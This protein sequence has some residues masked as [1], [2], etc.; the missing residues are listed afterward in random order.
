MRN[1][2]QCGAVTVAVRCPFC[3]ADLSFIP[4]FDAPGAPAAPDATR[5]MPAAPAPSFAPPPS[6]GRYQPAMADQPPPPMPGAGRGTKRWPLVVGVLVL[7]LVVA[8]AI[9][10][11]ARSGPDRGGAVPSPT[12]SA[13]TASAPSPTVSEPPAP[14]A[15]PVPAPAPEISAAPVAPPAV[16][17]PAV[18]VAPAPSRPVHADVIADATAKECRR[19]PNGPWAAV[20]VWGT[21][22]CPFAIN[23]HDAYLESGLGGRPGTVEAYS[24]TT[25]QWY[26]MTCSASNPVVTCQGGVRARILLYDGRLVPKK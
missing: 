21:T 2:P 16:T 17:P 19:L 6:A 5:V 1:C 13:P 18:T 3:G 26:E 7:V 4:P 20:G 12:T 23:V 25:E 15:A 14:A 11:F 24:P 8:L 9:W 10:W 22:S